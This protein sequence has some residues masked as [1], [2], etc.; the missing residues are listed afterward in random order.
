MDQADVELHDVAQGQLIE[1]GSASTMGVVVVLNCPKNSRPMINSEASLVVD[2]IDDSRRV[3]SSI[4]FDS[5]FWG[6]R[7]LESCAMN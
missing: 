3:P 5:G 7:L 2:A 4:G 1:P 6:E